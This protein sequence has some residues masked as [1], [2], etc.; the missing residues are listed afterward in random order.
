M[1]GD[2][3]GMVWGVVEKYLLK[4]FLRGANSARKFSENR[5]RVVSIQNPYQIHT[6]F[7]YLWCFGA[8]WALPDHAQV[9][10]EMADCGGYMQ[11][12][13]GDSRDAHWDDSL[14]GSTGVSL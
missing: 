5:T 14:G 6:P 1:G 11:H 4:H 13:R 9:M 3:V 8:P 10:P 7:P 12:G 2:G